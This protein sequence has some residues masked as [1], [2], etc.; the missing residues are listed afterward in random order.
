M[1]QREGEWVKEKGARRQRGIDAVRIDMVIGGARWVMK[2]MR[3]LFEEKG[4]EGEE[5]RGKCEEREEGVK[6]RGE[7]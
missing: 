5:V 3:D 7:G 2:Q 1:N 6:R 4:N